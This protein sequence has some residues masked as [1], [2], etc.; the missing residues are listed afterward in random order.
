MLVT[1]S[2]RLTL[3]HTPP[4]EN[5]PPI[6]VH[7]PAHSFQVNL[8]EV[9][10]NLRHRPD[11]FPRIRLSRE[12]KRVLIRHG[13]P[14][15]DDTVLHLLG[16]RVKLLLEHEADTILLPLSFFRRYGHQ[17]TLSFAHASNIIYAT[18]MPALPAV[19]AAVEAE[20][21]SVL[22]NDPC[23]QIIYSSMKEGLASTPAAL[24]RHPRRCTSPEY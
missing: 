13:I 9:S 12:S 1:L 6:S 16:G 24:I 20:A 3:K 18:L 7:F 22:Q 10:V 15:T 17:L 19:V 8:S 21:D 23:F 2:N 14:L 5:T 4:G 11:L